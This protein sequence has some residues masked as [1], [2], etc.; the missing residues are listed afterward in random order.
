MIYFIKQ[1]NQKI[2]KN[3][4]WILKR[5]IVEREKLNKN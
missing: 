2:Q 3:M 4:Y 5:K 1:N